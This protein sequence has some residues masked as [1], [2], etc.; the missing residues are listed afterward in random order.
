MAFIED[1]II[2]GFISK[3]INNCVDVSWV[4]IKKMAK[5]KKYQNIE[6]QIYNIIISVLNQITFN[7]YESD[8]DKIYQSAE[9]LLVGCRKANCVNIEVIRSGL[10][11][12]EECVNDDKY[13]QFKILLY[14]EL[15]KEDYEELYRVIELWQRDEKIVRQI[16]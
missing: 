10:Q 13:M 16:E 2:S 7:K 11:V 9:K 14:Q 1:A 3:A 4:K 6:S 8:Q 5:N 12:L 15:S